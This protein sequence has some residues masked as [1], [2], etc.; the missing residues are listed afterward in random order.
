M[1]SSTTDS[2]LNILKDRTK[3]ARKF[4]D[5]VQEEIKSRRL[6]EIIENNEH[7]L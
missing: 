1:S 7:I 3:A 5:D 6:T 4:E 2:C